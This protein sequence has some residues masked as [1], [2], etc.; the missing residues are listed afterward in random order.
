MA[1]LNIL[2]EGQIVQGDMRTN[3]VV[4][5]FPTSQAFCQGLQAAFRRKNSV[6]LI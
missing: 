6:E 4:D 1:I 3:I 5:P 2:S